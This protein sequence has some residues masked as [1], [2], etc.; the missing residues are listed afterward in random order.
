MYRPNKETKPSI[1]YLLAYIAKG[2]GQAVKGGRREKVQVIN[3]KNRLQSRAAARKSEAS[4]SIT[5]TQR[6]VGLPEGL[7]TDGV[8][9]KKRHTPVRAEASQQIH[10]L[11]CREEVQSVEGQRV[12]LRAAA[13]E[14]EAEKDARL[15]EEQLAPLNA[16]PEVDR[17]WA[18]ATMSMSPEAAVCLLFITCEPCLLCVR[19]TLQGSSLRW[20]PT[21]PR[22]W[23][24]RLPIAC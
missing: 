23:G 6:A 5:S 4:M 7:T 2:D 13:R 15:H 22:C 21:C 24:W 11:M 20:Q 19:T 18:V 10:I 9:H 3:G 16:S 1:E 8:C 17:P 14:T 12:Q